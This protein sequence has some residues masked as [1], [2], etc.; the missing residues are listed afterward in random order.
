L[1]YETQPDRARVNIQQISRYFRVPCRDHLTFTNISVG[2]KHSGEQLWH[3]L[4]NIL[5]EGFALAQYQ[6]HPSLPDLGNALLEDIPP[7][8][9]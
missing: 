6:M 1:R 5:P 9:G 3:K 8:L 2:A 4:T 7:V